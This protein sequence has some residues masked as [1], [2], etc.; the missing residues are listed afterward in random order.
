[1]SLFTHTP[2]P[3]SWVSHN[4][5]LHILTSSQ[6]TLAESPSFKLGLQLFRMAQGKGMVTAENRRENLNR[7]LQAAYEK[8]NPIASSSSL[9][10]Q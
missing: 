2:S 4:G 3:N 5:T 9:L 7:A 6:Q 10:L 8:D 1:M